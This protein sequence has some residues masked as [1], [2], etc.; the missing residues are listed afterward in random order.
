MCESGFHA[1]CPSHLGSDRIGKLQGPKR[2]ATDVHCDR[3]P[4]LVLSEGA[5]KKGPL[6]PQRVVRT[7][8]GQYQYC[9]CMVAELNP[10]FVD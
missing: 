9:S 8:R 2:S 1:P 10:C 5:E 4:T 6:L 3:P 7:V